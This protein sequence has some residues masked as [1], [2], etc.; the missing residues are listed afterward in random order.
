MPIIRPSK[1]K[2]FAA[3]LVEGR[4]FSPSYKVMFS[5]FL[6][7]MRSIY[8]FWT[9]RYQQGVNCENHLQTLSFQIFNIAN[10]Q[11]NEDSPFR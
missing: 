4:Y 2:T 9:L 11:T 3:N 8:L 5:R 7:H 10:I 1:K 6:F